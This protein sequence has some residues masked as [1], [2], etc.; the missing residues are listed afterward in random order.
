MMLRY[1]F[2]LDYA[3]KSK[4]CPKSIH[5]ISLCS[6]SYAE[7]VNV[8]A[9]LSPLFSLSNSVRSCSLFFLFLFFFFFFSAEGDSVVEEL[10]RGGN[11]GDDWTVPAGAIPI[12]CVDV[13]TVWFRCCPVLL[14]LLLFF[15]FLVGVLFFVLCLCWWQQVI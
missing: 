1:I 9:E 15:F 6:W 2:V 5:S 8:T 13:V 10:S 12:W 3:P 14:F 11:F 4:G 7:L